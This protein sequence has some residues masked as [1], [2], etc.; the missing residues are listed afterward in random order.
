MA[1]T[2]SIVKKITNGG[3][4]RIIAALV[5]TALVGA[6]LGFIMLR[7]GTD[8][9]LLY[10][11]LDLTESA[12]ISER[13]DQGNIR[14]SVRGDGASIYVNRDQVSDARLML[15]EEGLPTQGSMGYEIFDKSDTLGTTSFVQNINRVRALEGELA[16]TIGSLDNIRGARVHLVLPE[17]RLFERDTQ[18]PSASVVMAVAGR[19][20]SPSQVRAIRNLVAGSV[21][22]LEVNRITLLDDKGR[23]LAAGAENSEN[24]FSGGSA[25]ER[26]IAIEQQIRSKVLAVVESV[27]GPGAARVEV[28]ADIDFNRI[29]QSSEIFDPEGRVIRSSTTTEDSSS[30]SSTDP[31]GAVTAGNNVPDGDAANEPNDPTSQAQTNSL[32]ETTN[33]EISKTTKT[34]ITEGGRVRKI[35]VAVAIDDVRVLGEEGEEAS[36]TPRTEDEIA[37]ILTLVRSAV[38]YDEARGDI[39]EV[40]NVSFMRPESS[41]DL[42]IEEPG[43]MGLTKNDIM[44]ISELLGLFVG[45]ILLILFV[46]RPLV[47]GL[48]SPAAA[49]GDA[50]YVGEASLPGGTAS[51]GVN[52]NSN[53]VLPGSENAVGDDGQPIAGGGSSD[54][55]G[56]DVA[57]I[58][59]KVNAS[60]VKKISE[61]VESHPDESIQIIRA[62]LAED[63]N[64]GSDAA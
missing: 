63:H 2:V 7:G 61:V 22:D 12:E 4:M 54:D 28:A 41:L 6:G 37:N 39:V 10:S 34:E 62:W 46:L 57:R 59:G 14:Y 11:G 42:A 21:P 5:V 29:T 19:G 50:F 18:S 20:M 60:S 24:G 53:L 33:Y 27:T 40:V 35:S 36:F 38:G 31:S 23:L 45:A 8:E 30:E 13:L 3:Q 15:S 48:M 47:K 43:M 26:Q 55:L 49:S 16:R 17:R 58:S 25:D 56:L 32:Q 51:T 9:A 1:E 64:K 44:R 52:V